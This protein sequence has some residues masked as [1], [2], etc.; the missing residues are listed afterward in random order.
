MPMQ[1]IVPKIAYVLEFLRKDILEVPFI[2]TY[3]KDYFMPD[4]SGSD[5]WE[6]YDWDEKWAHLQTK[7]SAVRELYKNANLS[8]DLFNLLDQSTTE[9]EVL[10]LCIIF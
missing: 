9:T 7:K 8:Q 4:L 10:I 3:R 2:L 1:S 5:L 6:I